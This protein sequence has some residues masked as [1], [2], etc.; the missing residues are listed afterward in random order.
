[1][2]ET[3]NLATMTSTHSA[4]AQVRREVQTPKTV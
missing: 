1:M 4:L 3:P 2:K